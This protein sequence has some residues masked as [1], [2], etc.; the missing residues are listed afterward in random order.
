MWKSNNVMTECTGR[1]TR[2][3]Q[4]KRGRFKYGKG[5]FENQ[6]KFSEKR[7]RITLDEARNT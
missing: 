6:R 3:K 7:D 5:N 2:H 4:Y 1:E